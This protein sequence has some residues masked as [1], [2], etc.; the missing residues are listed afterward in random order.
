MRVDAE[1]EQAQAVLE[2]V[3]PDRLVPLEQLL[4]APDVVDQDV[5]PA[6]LGADALDQRFDLVGHQ[7]IDRNGDALAAG[8]RTTSSAVSSMVSG[9]AYSDCCSRVVRPVT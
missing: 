5:E 8:R 4:A 2:I 1:P 6:L 7:M 9:R 3:L